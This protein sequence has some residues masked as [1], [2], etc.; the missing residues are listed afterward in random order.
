MPALNPI[1]CTLLRIAECGARLLHSLSLVVMGVSVGYQAWPP[2]G[3]CHSVVIG[4]SKYSLGMPQLQC[5]VGPHHRWEF[6][7]FFKLPGVGAV[8]GDCKIVYSSVKLG[9]NLTLL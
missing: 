4:W 6:P 1:S 5:I 3:W 7:L 9:P 2:I 8:Q